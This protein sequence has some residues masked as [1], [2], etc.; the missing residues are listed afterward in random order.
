MIRDN[1]NVVEC[2][3]DYTV[4]WGFRYGE[5]IT[6]KREGNVVYRFSI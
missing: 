5:D 2:R 4:E 6:V 1:N 3:V